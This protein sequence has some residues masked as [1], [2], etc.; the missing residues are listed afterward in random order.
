MDEALQNIEH[1][2]KLNLSRKKLDSL[3]HNLFKLKNLEYLDLSKNRLD[4]LPKE[5]KALQNL[6]YINLSK[7]NFIDLLRLEAIVLLDL[8]VNYQFFLLLH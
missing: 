1:V 3:P 7:N 2:Y 5:L 6:E 4:H 8:E